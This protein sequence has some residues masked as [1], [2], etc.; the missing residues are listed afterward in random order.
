MS[1]CNMATRYNR[2]ETCN[3]VVVTRKSALLYAHALFAPTTPD[4]T[5]FVLTFVLVPTQL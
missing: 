5:V 4:C 3:A 1:S 2:T